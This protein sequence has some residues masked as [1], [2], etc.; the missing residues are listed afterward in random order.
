[1][2]IRTPILK[3]FVS[4][5]AI[6]YANK[7]LTS[8]WIGCGPRV[9]EFE[10]KISNIIK[11]NLFLAVNS[12]SSALNLA[13]EMCN[14]VEGDEVISTPITCLATNIPILARNAKPVW[15]DIKLD[16]TIDPAQVLSK[17]TEKTKAIVAVHFGG[18]PCDIISLN[19]IAKDFNIPVIEDAAH[20]LGAYYEDKPIGCHSD[21]VCF[22]F[23]SVKILTTVDGGGISFKNQDNYK[24]CKNKRFFGI[25]RENRI[26]GDF[27]IEYI[28][29]K[30][31]MNDVIA[32]IGL[33]NLKHFNK[34]IEHNRTLA[35]KYI[36]NLSNFSGLHLLF[37][38]NCNKFPS[39]WLFP[40]LAQN[41]ND[42]QRKLY[43][44]GIDSNPIHYRN[45]KVKLFARY[46]N[47]YLPN[48]E[49]LSK[50]M[51][52]LPIGFWVSIEEVERICE[53]IKGGW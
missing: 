27:N 25:D 50:E 53:I 21:F 7:T 38:N 43:E 17:I 11:N 3:P 44:H 12:C 33:G 15:A 13:Y 1:M 31:E 20:A 2:K 32:S 39:F 34:L 46:K 48:T 51:L 24:I 45:D 47:S 4:K 6:E 35:N 40:I 26:I 41:K 30:M 14:I 23:Q 19:K 10:R 5:E 49:R 18:N 9:K 8:N 29:Y 52:C 37:N 42:L 36:T 28:G 16:G 22:S